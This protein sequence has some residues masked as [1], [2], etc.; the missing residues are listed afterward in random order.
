MQ[1]PS[2]FNMD[3]LNKLMESAKPE[4]EAHAE[5]ANEQERWSWGT[6]SVDDICDMAE[7]V[8]AFME[9]QLDHP[10]L[11]KVLLDRIL[12]RMIGWHS[13]CGVQESQEGRHKSAL[14]WGRDAGKFQAI[15]NILDTITVCNDDFTVSRPS[16]S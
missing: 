4:A 16:D 8:E 15:A 6:A 11:A 5:L 7:R 14:M 13:S 2:S 12:I 3:D 9:E 10:I 1:A